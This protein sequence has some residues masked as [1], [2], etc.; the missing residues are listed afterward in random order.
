MTARRPTGLGA[1]EARWLAIGAQGLGRPRPTRAPGRRELRAAIGRL[2]VVQLDAINVLARTQFLVLFSRL[3]AY[4]VGR[5][6]A[7]SGPGGEV[8]EYWA[9]AASIVPMA[10]QPLHRWRMARHGSASDTPARAAVRRAW[11]DEHAAYLSSVMAEVAERGALTAGQLSDPRRSDGEWWDRRSLGRV[12]LEALFAEGALAAWRTPSF[13][14]IYDLPERVVP[15]EILEQPT[16]PEDEAHRRLLVQ[17]A[18]ALGVATVRDLA[19]YYRLPVRVTAT[20]VAELVEEGSLDP[21]VVEGWRD[22]AY[23]RPGTRVA[24]PTRDHATVLSPF[25]SLVWDRARTSR[26]FGFDYRIEV[27]TPE[28]DRRYGYFV[29]PLLLGDELVGRLDLKADRRAGGALRVPAAHLEPG[30]DGAV[31]AQ[32]AAAELRA[33]SGWLGLGDVAVGERGDLAAA[34]GRAVGG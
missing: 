23:I 5:V 26:V 31:V 17:S 16:P 11:L 27:Y 24:R 12:A 4:D 9:H 21:V 6:H 1:V 7:M 30:A 34:L 20:R 2:G 10:S 33:L 13:E 3:G 22:T 8:L 29:M 15:A 14:R 18:D 32:A 28:P 25:D 19:D